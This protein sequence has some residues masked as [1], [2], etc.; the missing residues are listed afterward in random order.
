R[1]YPEIVGEVTEATIVAPDRLAVA[2][3]IAFRGET[4]AVAG[5][6]TV[7]RDGATIRIE[8]EQSFD[9][10]DWGLQPPRVGLLKV[11]PEVTVRV[12][13]TATRA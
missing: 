2:G 10:R 9:V 3:S 8:G 4:C 6:L 12:A 7:T 13:I 11:S 5:E 1:R